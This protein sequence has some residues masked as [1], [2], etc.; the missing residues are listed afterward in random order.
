MALIDAYMCKDSWTC[1][2]HSM[3]ELLPKLFE[4]R[5]EK[6]S[7]SASGMY[8]SSAVYLQSF[9]SPRGKSIF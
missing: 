8:K 4:K 6:N 9:S 2:K 5:K 7:I 3:T 1:S